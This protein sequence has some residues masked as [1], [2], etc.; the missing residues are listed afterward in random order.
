MTSKQCEKNK[1]GSHFYC[2]Q[3]GEKHSFKVLPAIQAD[4]KWANLSVRCTLSFWSL[5]L[6]QQVSWL[7]PVRRVPH[8]TDSLQHRCHSVLT[9]HEAGQFAQ[10]ILD[11]NKTADAEM[12]CG[13]AAMWWPG[14]TE[15]RQPGGWHAIRTWSISPH[16]IPFVPFLFFE[17]ELS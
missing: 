11:Q 15:S 4:I 14:T 1:T 13:H 5:V 9:V 10:A 7:P 3:Q 2:F 16:R 6:N 17:K 8:A 12:L